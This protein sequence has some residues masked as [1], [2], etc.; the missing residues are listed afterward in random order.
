M[1][2]SQGAH[3]L[4]SGKHSVFCLFLLYR[5]SLNSMSVLGI[6]EVLNREGLTRTE[7]L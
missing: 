1:K 3:H 7:I 5:Y 2:I 6:K 4:H